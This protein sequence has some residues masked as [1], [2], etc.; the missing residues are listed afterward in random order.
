M[1]VLVSVL[2]LETVNVPPIVALFITCRL[3]LGISTRPDPFAI[4][5]KSV[6]LAVPL[7][8]DPVIVTLGNLKY[9]DPLSICVIFNVDK[10]PVIPVSP[11]KL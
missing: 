9:T 7:I 11:V 3:L 1:D 6:L 4:N 10:L 8:L 5:C 2:V